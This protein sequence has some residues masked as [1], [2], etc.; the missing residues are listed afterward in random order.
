M[1]GR[2]QEVY[3]KCLFRS[4][5]LAELKAELLLRNVNFSPSDSYLILT[6]KLRRDIL[7]KSDDQPDIVDLINQEIVALDE[8]KPAGGS[9]YRCSVV[10][11][12]FRCPSHLKYMTHLQFVHYNSKSRLACQYRHSC[13]RD[14]PN[15]S[16]LKSH[17]LNCHTRAKTTVS[18]RQNMLVEELTRLECQEVSCGH[19]SAGSIQL[20]KKHLYTHTNKSEKVK[21]I[22]CAYETSTTGTLKS[23]FSKS[24]KVQ[25]IA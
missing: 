15:F 1:D 3:S 24:H 21:C 22:F 18:V 5:S 11:C 17:V 6:L 7:V 9:R 20:L 23:H 25:T 10:G 2:D 16:M 8:T 14:F 12:T 13:S 4:I 19:Q